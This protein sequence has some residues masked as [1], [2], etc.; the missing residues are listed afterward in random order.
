[1]QSLSFKL[2]VKT[3]LTEI[4]RDPKT[5]FFT[6][7][8]PFF[9]L[10][11]FGVMDS[12]I[13]PSKELNVSFLEYL[14]PGILVFALVSIGLIGTS[15]PIIEMRVKGILKTLKITPLKLE[16]FVLSQIVVR[17][18]LSICQIL[19]FTLLGFVLGY[20]ELKHVIPFISI[21]LLGMVM[22]LTIGFFFGNFFNNVELA[23]GVLSS[24]MVPLLMLSG[25]LL[26][27]HILP[28]SIQ[29]ISY[30]IPFTYLI[31]LYHHTLFGI[32]GSV[33]TL[34]GISIIFLVSF[35]FFYFTVK[36]FKWT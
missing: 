5:L 15:V 19:F 23:S 21:S 24:F 33:S 1:M 11:M 13:V 7:L 4:I 8:F 36:T 22:I 27:T 25:A 9:F 26:P 18:I 3:G 30:V 28:E 34:A 14:F 29:N 32:E 16:T 12:V 17:F 35:V 10:G 31:D 2:L 20:I 6:L